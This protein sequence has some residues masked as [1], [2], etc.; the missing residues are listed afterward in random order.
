MNLAALDLNL[1][2]ALHAL[3]EERSVTRAAKRLG[4]SQPAASNALA[5]LRDALGDPLFVR[6]GAAMVPTPRAEAMAAPLAA[7]LLALGR[8]V[9]P[10]LPF[11]P[12]RADDR[13]T[14]AATDYVEMVL[15]P[16]ITARVVAAAPRIA[17]DVRPIGEESPLDA[18]AAGTLDGALGVFMQLPPGFH[19]SALGSERF[20]GIARRG[21]PAVGRRP[22]SI[23]AW[24]A[25]G[26]V[27]VTP[28]RTGPAA[29][30]RAL[31]ERGLARHVALYVSHFLVAPLVVAET[32]L[33]ATLPER[34]ARL[35]AAELDLVFFEPPIPLSG[36]ELVQLWHER[37]A[38]SAAHVWLRGAI[39]K[40]A[41][42][43]I[44]TKSRK[45]GA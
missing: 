36:F 1:L 42:R 13:F 10:P 25:L 45:R 34:A 19:K 20:V 17:L 28:R 8:A 3:L 6:S 37:T 18:L 14:F 44:K 5:R 23:E 7:A 2:T 39:D 30:D 15:L 26:H 38:A 31:A 9:T 16:R 40:A 43:A 21:H 12:A 41:P 4:L 27:L 35:L 32:D 22:L 33:V 24:A 29:V 11:D